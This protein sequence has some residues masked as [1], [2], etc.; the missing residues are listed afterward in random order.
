MRI[1]ICGA[2]QVGYHIARQLAREN[3]EVVLIDRDE[4]LIARINDTLDVQAIRGYASYPAVLAAAGAM[5]ADMLIAVT[6]S[7]E[8]NMVACQVA[9]ALFD[10]PTKI[11]RIRDQNYLL[12]EWKDLYRHDHLP[13]DYIISPEVEVAQ[14]I[15]RRLHMP[16]AID[17]FPFADDRLRVLAVR[18][19]K[20]A[21]L[22]NLP[23]S[24]IRSRME[25]LTLSILGIIHDT[26]FIMPAPDLILSEGDTVYFVCRS[27]QVR[28]ALPLFGH[29]E[30]EARRLVI[31]GGGNIGLYIA[32]FLEENEQDTRV[33]IIEL[34][35]QRAEYIAD[36]LEQTTV[37][38][39][40]GLD[41]DVLTEC[42]IE[43][44]EAII[45]VTN[46][47][48]VNIL[49]SL[50]AKRYGCQRSV[51][52]VNN[53]A[54]T[55]LLGNLG[56]DVI[57]NPRESTV[58]SILQYIRRGKIR[59]VHSIHDGAAEV[60]EAEVL[61]TSPLLGKQVGQLKLPKGVVLGAIARKAEILIPDA[62]T[63]IHEHDLIIILSSAESVK[64]VE[65]F[66]S[67]SLEF[68]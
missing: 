37:V 6:Y 22:N 15:L 63:V 19:E 45:C 12:P 20:H 35:R 51:A 66:F 27:D 34:S 17:M 59:A 42:G 11:A 67:V 50:L 55:P 41:G 29:H 49:A 38:S 1:I 25:G 9:H 21:P 32:K 7:D 36:K 52:L 2:G 4:A 62:D 31:L 28:K 65:Q 13:I 53:N 26:K 60:I 43:H 3:N 56:V 8:V 47:D 23:L 61:P 46:D 10:I 39:G 5:D 64:K 44:T 30:K 33:K 57:V 24:V 54:Y 40:S 48:K 68:F 14:A 18:S 58:S 16:G